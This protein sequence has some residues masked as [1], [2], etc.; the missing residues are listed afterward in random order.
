MFAG[1]CLSAQFFALLWVLL[2]CLW[3][4]SW[5]PL[6]PALRSWLL[7]E[8]SY[9]LLLPRVVLTWSRFKCLC[10]R[11]SDHIGGT[12]REAWLWLQKPRGGL[13]MIFPAIE[14]RSPSFLWGL[15][16]DTP[17]LGVPGSVLLTPVR[18]WACPELSW[19]WLRKAASGA[20]FPASHSCIFAVKSATLLCQ[21]SHSF[22]MILKIFCPTFSMF[23]ASR[24]VR[25]YLFHT[26][27][28]QGSDN[29]LFHLTLWCLRISNTA[30]PQWLMTTLECF[31]GWNID[32]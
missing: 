18:N 1:A 7:S 17:T 23:P 10:L 15:L 11:G 24:L 32:S 4:F 19:C 9:L 8:D 21:F 31:G 28:D 5:N 3:S 14:L 20:L 12:S 26:A 2:R 16:L 30:S 27:G 13:E 22:K 25:I 6:S 29:V